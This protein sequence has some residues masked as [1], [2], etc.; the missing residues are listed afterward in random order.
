MELSPSRRAV[1]TGAVGGAAAM[2]LWRAPAHADPLPDA[3]YSA[4]GPVEVLAEE[5]THGGARVLVRPGGSWTLL[6]TDLAPRTEHTIR[7]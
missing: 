7:F 6:L 3:G 4:S 1:L 2:A 5:S